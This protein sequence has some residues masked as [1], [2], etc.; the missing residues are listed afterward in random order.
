[1]KNVLTL[2]IY[3]YEHIHIQC[4]DIFHSYVLPFNVHIQIL[5]FYIHAKFRCMYT[6]SYML[7]PHT[8]S[9]DYETLESECVH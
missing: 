5:E 8:L 4:Q 7:S 9:L 3:K 6:L 1:M 2:Y